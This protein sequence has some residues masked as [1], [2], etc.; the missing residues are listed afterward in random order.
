MCERIA[1][2]RLAARSWRVQADRGCAA[3]GRG[4]VPSRLER[5]MKTGERGWSRRGSG[6]R[7]RPTARR[8]A[9]ITAP[10][11]W[12]LRDQRGWRPRPR[13]SCCGITPTRVR[14]SG[15]PV[16]TPLAASTRLLCLFPTR[17]A[18][19]IG[20]TQVVMLGECEIRILPQST[21][22]AP[23]IE[24]AQGWLLVR[25]ESSATLKVGLGDRLITLDVP[26]NGCAALERSARWVYGRLV[27]P[28]PPLLVHGVAG[29]I[30]GHGR[31]QA[32][33]ARPARRPFDR[34]QRG[35]AV[36]GRR[37][38]HVGERGRGRRRRDQGARCS[39]PKCFHP[40][41]A[42]AHG[43][44]RRRWKTEC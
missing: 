12:C 29:E 17:T 13:G 26:Q 2:A 6:L 8:S 39:L 37:F 11:S 38:A 10:N 15:S 28:V 40:R 31:Q 5:L 4:G 1:G 43:N 14:G 41:P 32:G 16:P 30:V 34:P 25:A 21:E 19:A 7:R 24:L 22:A 33:G 3:E 9:G 18:V 35:E 44:R 42:G 27:S 23:A 36:D 20:K